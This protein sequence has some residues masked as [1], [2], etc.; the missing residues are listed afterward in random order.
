VPQTGTPPVVY[1]W[2]RV[3]L[4]YMLDHEWYTWFAKLVAIGEFAVGIG[5]ILGAFVGIAA[6]F[7]TVMN[8]S[9]LLAGSAS[10]N[11]VLFGLAVFLILAWK[12]SG[13]IG[14]DRWL[15]PITRTPWQWLPRRAPE[16]TP[17]ARR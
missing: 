8:F 14:L 11:P 1:G 6:F 15:L 10:S 7:G 16:G 9:Y 3:F 4:K 13:L 5:L 2:Y 17:P 12:V